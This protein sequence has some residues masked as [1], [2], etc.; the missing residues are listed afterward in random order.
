MRKTIA[1]IFSYL[2]EYKLRLVVVALCLI[3]NTGAALVGGYML[4]PILNHVAEAGIPA[5]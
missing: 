1:R 4:R 5:A 2:G 3:L